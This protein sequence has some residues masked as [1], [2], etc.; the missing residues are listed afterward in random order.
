MAYADPQS[1]TVTGAASSLPRTG[2]GI[3]TGN[4]TSADGTVKLTVSHAYG[5]RTRRQL[6]VDLKK[7]A[8]DPITAQNAYFGASAYI[9]VDAPPVGFTNAELV[10]L[11]VG[12]ADYLKASTNAAATKLVGGES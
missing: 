5:K 1:I 10:T 2:S 12:L 3:A 11:I 4:F 7:I 8:A 9:V 6:R